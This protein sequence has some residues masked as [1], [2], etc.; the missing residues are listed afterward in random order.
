[1]G[2]ISIEG[3]STFAIGHKYAGDFL[4]F[5][6]KLSSQCKIATAVIHSPMGNPMTESVSMEKSVST[7]KRESVDLKDLEPDKKV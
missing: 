4:S 5:M 3:N 2:Y 1:M 6:D 7:S